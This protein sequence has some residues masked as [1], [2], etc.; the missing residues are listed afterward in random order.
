MLVD[1]FRDVYRSHFNSLR[2]AIRRSDS[3]NGIFS[4]AV[5]FFRPR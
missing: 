1:R 2:R 4:Y 5:L 3:V